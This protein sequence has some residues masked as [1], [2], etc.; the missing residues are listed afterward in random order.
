[1]L[2][3]KTS[4]PDEA[5]LANILAQVDFLQREKAMLQC[6]LPAAPSLQA[7]SM[8][9]P[10]GLPAQVTKCCSAAC[11]W[12]ASFL[13]HSCHCTLLP[14]RPSSSCRALSALFMVNAVECPC[15]EMTVA[16]CISLALLHGCQSG[17]K[18][19]SRIMNA[20]PLSGLADI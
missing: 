14:E 9:H 15:A 4:M 12:S 2:D 18:E 16:C 1:M 17:A 8:A 13:T 11:G 20:V 6:T 7:A 19:S 5:M 10:L 3:G